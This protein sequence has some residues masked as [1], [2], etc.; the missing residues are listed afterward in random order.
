MKYTKHIPIVYVDVA[1][2]HATIRVMGIFA[3]ISIVERVVYGNIYY[4][5]NI[6]AYREFG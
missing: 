4:F 5:I 2:H 3:L 1:P 6:S